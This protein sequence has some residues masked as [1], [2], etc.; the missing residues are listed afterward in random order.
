LKLTKKVERSNP[1]PP[2]AERSLLA[3]T[4]E[5]LTAGQKLLFDVHSLESIRAPK[6]RERERETLAMKS[7]SEADAATMPSS[8]GLNH[9]TEIIDPDQRRHCSDPREH[10][11]NIFAQE[12]DPEPDTACVTDEA[13]DFGYTSSSSSYREVV[14]YQYEVQTTL[15]MTAPELNGN[16]LGQLEKALADYLVPELFQGPLCEVDAFREQQDEGE[17]GSGSLDDLTGLSSDPADALAPGVEAG[18]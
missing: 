1:S 18:T 12:I 17:G 2:F 4:I 6:T 11:S 7:N 14:E 8:R 9:C 3:H 16:V 10:N 15:A 5:A 13:G